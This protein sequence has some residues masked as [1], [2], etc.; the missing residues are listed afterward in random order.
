PRCDKPGRA[1]SPITPAARQGWR[2]ADYPSGITTVNA[3]CGP[4]DYIPSTGRTITPGPARCI[5]SYVL[6]ERLIDFEGARQLEEARV[7]AHLDVNV[8]LVRDFASPH[9]G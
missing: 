7:R 3:T 4:Q 6:G 5:L 8:T 2:K 9:N 1:C